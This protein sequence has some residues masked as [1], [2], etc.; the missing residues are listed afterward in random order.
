LVAVEKALGEGEKVGQTSDF[1][2]E[3]V[4]LRHGLRV[5]GMGARRLGS[6]KGM[7]WARDVGLM[8]V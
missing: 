6:V 5:A 3:E 2:L 1:V 4:V 8:E 7:C